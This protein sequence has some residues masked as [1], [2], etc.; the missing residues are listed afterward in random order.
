M[1]RMEVAL[2]EVLEGIVWTDDEGRIE[3]TNPAFERMVGRPRI[4][5]LGS[6]L[7][8]LLLLDEIDATRAAEQV[9]AAAATIPGPGQAR[10]FRWVGPGGPLYLEISSSRLDESHGGPLVFYTIRDVT[11]RQGLLEELRQRALYDPV[12]GLANRSL[13]ADRVEHAIARMRRQHGPIAVLFL[14]V[15]AFKE[16][17]DNFGHDMGDQ[18]LRAIGERISAILRP[19]DTLARLSGDEFAILL[20]DLPNAEV[21]EEVARRIVTAFRKPLPVAGRS[22]LLSL[23]IGL[24]VALDPGGSPQSLISNADFAMYAA[25]RSGR[26]QWRRYISADREAAHRRTELVM[27]LGRAIRRGELVVHYQPIVVLR[28]GRVEGFEALVRWQHPTRGLMMPG[29]FIGIAEESGLI[30]Q[31]GGWVLE[32]ACR[33]LLTWQ[34][35]DPGLSISVNL[36]PRQLQHRGIVGQ[37]RR[38]LVRSGVE[39]DRLILEVTES[40][41]LTDEERAID[42]LRRLKALGV[43]L[44]FD[45]FGT[46]YS[47][48]SHLRRMPVDILKVDRQ[49]VDAIDAPDGR[50]LLR[51]IVDLGHSVGVSLVAEGIER[52]DQI[53]IL[54]AASVKSGQGYLLARPMPA[55]AVAPFL[56]SGVRLASAGIRGASGGRGRKKAG[57]GA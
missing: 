24:D 19:S 5:I 43:R 2:G 30:V 1:G 53:P 13:F 51:S 38:S 52:L 29:E 48:L 49:F 57:P 4:R 42:R 37:V 8:E 40:F 25:K 26:G 16:V 56:Q 17:N 55:E 21:A 46:G 14:D 6:R 33:D 10:T 47:S 50:R 35:T 34:A 11:Q 54:V 9:G 44:A 12:T 3:W 31:V 7:N 45:D 36:S 28:T 32:T 20:E 27:E 23:S 41:L 22:V 15:D 18:S 39:P